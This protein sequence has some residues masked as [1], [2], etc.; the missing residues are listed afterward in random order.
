MFYNELLHFCTSRSAY[1]AG[2]VRLEDIRAT[3]VDKIQIGSCF[4]PGDTVLAE[5]VSLGTS[6][7]YYLSTAHNHLGVV[8]A[9]SLA[10]MEVLDLLTGVSAVVTW[11]ACPSLLTGQPCAIACTSL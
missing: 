8:Y 10:G 2:A 6:R 9:K 11:N 4:R 5:V 1:V 7:D 3:E